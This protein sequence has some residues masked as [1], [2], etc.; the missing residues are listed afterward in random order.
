MTR[1]IIVDVLRGYD[2]VRSIGEIADEIVQRLS[3]SRPAQE[4]SS[5]QFTRDELKRLFHDG[6]PA[7]VMNL[8]FSDNCKDMTVGELRQ[9]VRRI[10][11]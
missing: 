3:L 11:D 6:V 8:V 9:F 2:E 7:D 4:P 1:E 5:E 10:W